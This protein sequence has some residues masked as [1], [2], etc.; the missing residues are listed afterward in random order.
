MSKMENNLTEE[1]II[2]MIAQAFVKMIDEQPSNVYDY[3]LNFKDYNNIRYQKILIPAPALP[4]DV[5][6]TMNLIRVSVSSF[7][8]FLL[9]EDVVLGEPDNIEVTYGTL[10][11]GV[12][13]G[14]DVCNNMIRATLHVTWKSKWDP[15]LS[16]KKGGL[17]D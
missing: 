13:D 10:E 7:V 2:Y 14:P 17:D 8:D 11:L 1:E 6:Q 3:E 16:S 12:D 5:E 9:K 4:R 15:A